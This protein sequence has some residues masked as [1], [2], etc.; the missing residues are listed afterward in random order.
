MLN[1]TKCSFTYIFNVRVSFLGLHAEGLEVILQGIKDLG[2]SPFIRHGCRIHVLFSKFPVLSRPL[3][4][5]PPLCHLV[6]LFFSVFLS[7]LFSLP[8]LPRGHCLVCEKVEGREKQFL[9]W[10]AKQG[11]LITLFNSPSKIFF[12]LRE[13]LCLSSSWKH[14]LHNKTNIKDNLFKLYT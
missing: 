10:Y 7:F 6:F 1:T 14:F 2:G 9:S 13:V 8:H 11:A 12:L 3:Y 5:L 4:F